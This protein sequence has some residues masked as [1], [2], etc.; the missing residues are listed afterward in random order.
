MQVALGKT[1]NDS[2]LPN[3]FQ[4]SQHLKGQCGLIFT[5]RKIAEVVEYFNS[6]ES[7]EF[8]HSG[9]VSPATITLDEGTNAF[10]KLGHSIE[11]YLRELGVSTALKNGKIQLTD[12][13]VLCEASKK[14]T[15]EQCRV[16]VRVCL[17]AWLIL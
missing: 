5:N 1:E 11:P 8:A 10:E 13:Y 16:L 2:L 7:D 4:I 14:L 9:D 3:S 12:R 6:Y 17:G 15:P